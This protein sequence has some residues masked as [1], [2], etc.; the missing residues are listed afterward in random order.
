M[1]YLSRISAVPL[2]IRLAAISFL[3][4]FSVE[5]SSIFLPLYA[6]SRGASTFQV[7]LIGSSYGIAYF[8]S[9][10]I[11]GRQ[12]DRHGRLL[13]VRLGLALGIVAYV[14]QITATDPL[15]LLAI[16]AFVGFC[17][18]ISSAAIMAYVYEAEG[19]VG[20]FA[21]YGSL[22]WLLGA[23]VAAV[24]AAATGA[25]ES[26]TTYYTLFAV[27]GAASA[28][29]LLLSF[30]LKEERGK[31]LHVPFFPLSLFRDNGRV[32][33][34]FFLRCLGSSAIWAVF[35]LFLV[36][37]HA[38]KLWVALLDAINMGLQFVFMRYVE[39]FNSAWVLA[40]GLVTSVVVFASYGLATHYQQLIPFQVLLA[41]SW[42]CLWVGSLSFL[43]GRSVERGTAAG[44]LYSMTYLSAGFG[45]LIGG[46]LA[47]RWDF[48]VLMFAASGVTF[49]GLV[50]SWVLPAN[51]QV[52]PSE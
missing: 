47:D 40:V 17:L 30:S 19:Q 36:S 1:K 5:S 9:S 14:L 42:S 6:N 15:T 3:F 2:P 49:L 27:S 46:L 13:F 32:Y 43:M 35:P 7:G 51:K 25:A 12:S 24:A 22:G 48:P 45:P 33:I 34:P 18:G 28:L 52:A 29:A 31:S 10:F 50:L 26:S 21:S 4:S 23:A 39:R 44:L 38:S 8:V 37:I 20:R 41:I 11:F 16:R